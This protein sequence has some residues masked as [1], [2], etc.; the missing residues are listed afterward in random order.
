MKTVA[1][2]S[3]KRKDDTMTSDLDNLLPAE[4]K[5]LKL[6]TDA[7]GRVHQWI[8]LSDADRNLDVLP[9]YFTPLRGCPTCSAAWE[10]LTAVAFNTS[11]VFGRF[12]PHGFFCRS[13][14]C[15]M[16]SGVKI[17]C[18][19][20][21][22]FAFDGCRYEELHSPSWLNP[23]TMILGGVVAVYGYMAQVASK[24]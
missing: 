18:T 17:R 16:V 13:A 12:E 15:S 19:G 14:G 23:L 3:A 20:G 22:L 10:E 7:E 8:S 24:S 4:P 2:L 6:A 21:H 9:D 1:A 5:R 11:H